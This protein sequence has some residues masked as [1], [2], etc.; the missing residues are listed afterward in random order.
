MT[1]MSTVRGFAWFRLRYQIASGLLVAVVLPFVTRFYFLLPTESSYQL[2][3]TSIGNAAA[4]MLTVWILRNITTYPGVEATSYVVPAVSI[5]F[6]TLLFVLIVGR[7]SYNRALLISAW[8]ISALWYVVLFARIQRYRK[9]RIGVV[10]PCDHHA[11]AGINTVEAI[12][13]VSTNLDAIRIDAVMADLRADIPSKW[14]RAL[15]DYALAGI[16]VYHLKHLKES[17]TGR[18]EL[19]HLSENNFGSLTPLSPFMF[20]KRVADWIAALIAFIILMPVFLLVATAI[21]WTSPGPV[22]FTQPRVGYRG[23]TFV[24]YK[25]RTMTASTSADEAIEAAMTKHQDK[26]ITAVGGFLRR[27]R[28]DELP[29][30]INI[31]KGNMSWIGPRPEAEVLS[32]WYEDEIPFYR[33]RHIVMPGITGWAQVNQGHVTNVH[34]VKEKLYFDFYYIKSFSLWMDLLI[35]NRTIATVVTGFGA[36]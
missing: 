13:L 21:W 27:T 8:I 35:I 15:A 36:R 26:R 3:T 31:L 7:I 2:Y 9:L 4:V 19:E 29:Q 17:L 16:P 10:P 22:L 25:F 14:D 32:K 11:L 20:T 24:V 28:L 34:E 18:V 33:Y 23:K 6:T 5:A 30:I 1:V 12:P